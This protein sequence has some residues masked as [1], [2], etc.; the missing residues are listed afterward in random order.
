MFLYSKA[1]ILRA[2]TLFDAEL[3]DLFHVSHKGE[4]DP[5]MWDTLVMSILDGK[6]NGDDKKLYG[7]AIRNRN[8]WL[9]PV[10]A[11]GFY[12]MAR[13]AMTK[14]FE[15][16]NCPDFTNNSSWYDIK[17]LI[18]YGTNNGE[19]SPAEGRKKKIAKDTY[20][21]FIKRILKKLGISSNHY[22][23]L[24]RVMGAAV[25]QLMERDEEEVRI[26]GNW[27]AT[28][29]DKAYSTK[30][31]LKA[32]RAAAGFTEAGGMFNCPRAAVEPPEDLQK[33]L[34]VFVDEHLQKVDE[35]IT[36][37]GND[38]SGCYLGAAKS[39]LEMLVR[40]RTIILQDMAAMVVSD[41]ISDE[42]RTRNHPLFCS[43]HFRHIFQSVEFHVSAVVC[44]CFYFTLLLL[45]TL[46]EYTQRMRT[47]LEVAP[48]TQ[49]VTV[50]AVLP[51][52]NQRLCAVEHAQRQVSLQLQHLTQMTERLP[53]LDQ[54][55][56]MF[57]DALIGAASSL[58]VPAPVR[59]V[60][61]RAAAP[62]PSNNPQGHSPS[63]SSPIGHWLNEDATSL[64]DYYD[65]WF[66]LG[67]FENVPIPG[68]I[69]ECEKKYKSSWRKGKSSYAMRISR[70]GRICRAMRKEIN[71]GRRTLDDI[72]LEFDDL[73]EKK[74]G[75]KSGLQAVITA[76][77][78]KGWIEKKAD[79]GRK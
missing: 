19:M 42:N 44:F 20:G 77:Q 59:A 22:L 54:V 52:L 6:T 48:T 56:R 23:H 30:L 4:I 1:G 57:Q 76:F 37:N 67:I 58:N 75:Q 72:C 28:V 50:D 43:C 26:L 18:S 51:G 24:G 38:K 27:S 16:T 68:G 79:R 7:C 49:N 13:F 11:F 45:T 17:L 46:K 78:L 14:E 66:G 60:A 5:H 64:K 12:C 33:K 36:R 63:A 10:G 34:F 41:E 21:K 40:L 35:E 73:F 55:T 47:A 9:C 25:L 8:V 29:R 15:G 2:E 71:E 32:M 31:P 39:F 70:Q 3:S 65:E 74:K 61:V 53:T 62:S 69:E